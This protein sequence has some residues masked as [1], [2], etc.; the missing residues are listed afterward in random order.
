MTT[1][2]KSIILIINSLEL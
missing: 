2:V 1:D